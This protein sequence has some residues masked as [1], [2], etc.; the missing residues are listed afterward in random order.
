[1][2]GQDPISQPFDCAQDRSPN[3]LISQSPNPPISQ[4]PNLCP[5]GNAPVEKERGRCL[6]NQ[7]D[8]L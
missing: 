2:R 8:G 5:K 4:S 7:A 6:K 1:M 3:L